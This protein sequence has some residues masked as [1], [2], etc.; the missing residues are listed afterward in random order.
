ME[1][2]QISVLHYRSSTKSVNNHIVRHPIRSHYGSSMVYHPE[3]SLHCSNR[4]I[5]IY[6]ILSHNHHKCWV[7]MMPHATLQ[8]HTLLDSVHHLPD[9]V[10]WTRLYSLICISKHHGSNSVI[11]V[12]R[13]LDIT[14]KYHS[15][16][17]ISPT[18][19][20]Q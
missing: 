7:S 17:S 12:H 10:S 4:M 6:N 5:Y 11:T 13:P 14:D 8:S 19:T 18:P 2:L 20:L 1:P 3:S 16:H 15:A 9:R